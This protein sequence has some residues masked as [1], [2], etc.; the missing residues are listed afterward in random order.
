MTRDP[1]ELDIGDVFQERYEVRGELGFG[2]R[3]RTYLAFDTKMDREVA[4]SV[5]R[6]DADPSD[7]EATEREAKVL[8]RIGSNDNIVSLYDY[9]VG[10]TPEYMVFEYLSGGT[11]AERLQATGPQPLDAV[12]R[13]G[14]QVGRGL[15]HLHA[16]GLIHRDISPAN[17]WL[18]G[19]GE[20]HLGDF[21]SA[22]GLDDVEVRLP[23]T[24]NAFAAPEEAAGGP[25]D[26]RS[27]LFSLG[28][29]LYCL[30]TGTERVE[31]MELLSRRT[32]LPTSYGDL[33]EALLEKDPDSRPESAEDV[34]DSLAAIRQASNLGALLR[35]DESNELEFKASLYH[36]YGPLPESYQKRLEQPDWT[37]ERCENALREDVQRGAAKSIA[38][39]LNTNGGTLVIG[40][41]DRD[42]E[43]LGIET[44]YDYLTMGKD[45]DGWL[46]QFQQLISSTLQA[47]TWNSIRVALVQHRGATVAVVS[48]PRRDVDTWFGRPGKEVF[49]IRGPNG[50]EELTGPGLVKFVREHWMSGAG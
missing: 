42:H 2:D 23:L 18:D 4:L 25:L 32:D 24:T 49:F 36:L 21:D 12:L 5:V 50:T 17:I 46:Q 28:G 22:V 1:S 6:P 26:V 3:K 45:A 40:V 16:Q 35:Q 33:V 27:D 13:L 30:A 47:E 15:A 10:T 29:V 19:R 43:V 7:P 34:L 31:S 38:A 14:R 37:L 11:L 41:S 39:F 8:G 20:A 44:D 9:E 48:C